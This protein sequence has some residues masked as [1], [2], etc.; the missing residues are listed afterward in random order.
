MSTTA[1]R[2]RAGSSI[3][4]LNVLEISMTSVAQAAVLAAAFALTA[5]PRLDA[6]SSS[7]RVSIAGGQNAGTHEMKSDDCTILNGEIAYLFTAT[8]ETPR[9]APVAVSFLTAAGK[10][11]P[12]GFG[13]QVIFL[14]Q[15]N[16][17]IKYE[18]HAM[19]PGVKNPHFIPNSGRGTVTVKKT[20]TGQTAAFRGQTKDGV[21]MEG[22][23]DCRTR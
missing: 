2:Q 12:D 20:A 19:P 8:D 11:K 17:Q 1:V 4:A 23:V 15:Y 6:Q 5:L 9:S 10:G 16:R 22:S 18:I 3:F 7:I 13:V 14:G 21:K